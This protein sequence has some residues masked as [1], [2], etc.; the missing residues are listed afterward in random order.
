MRVNENSASQTTFFLFQMN[1]I[2]ADKIDEFLK[3]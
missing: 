2:C 3:L 1:E